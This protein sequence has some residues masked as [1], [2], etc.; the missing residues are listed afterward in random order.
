M[1]QALGQLLWQLESGP[2]PPTIR[3]QQL[4]AVLCGDA[5]QVMKSKRSGW[6]AGAV[7]QLPAP[8]MAPK[9]QLNPVSMSWESLGRFCWGGWGLA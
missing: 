4:G 2:G 9:I 5:V 6:A 8:R 7:G 1:S 3:K